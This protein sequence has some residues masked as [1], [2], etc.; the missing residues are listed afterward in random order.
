[1]LFALMFLLAQNP[2]TSNI[3][4]TKSDGSVNVLPPLDAS[5]DSKPAIQAAIDWCEGQT[6]RETIRIPPGTWKI[7]NPLELVTDITLDLTMVEI[8]PFDATFDGPLVVAG[9]AG[10]GPWAGTRARAD[11]VYILGGTL[12][13]NVSTSANSHGMFVDQGDHWR[14]TNLTVKNAKH[15]GIV[16][17]GTTR[18]WFWDHVE[19]DDCGAGDAFRTQSGAGLNCNGFSHTLVRCVTHRCGQG[20]ESAGSRNTFI[21]CQAL[22]GNTAAGPCTGFTLGN[23][24]TGLYRA[25]L[26]DCKS[27]GH[28]TAVSIGNVDGRCGGS[29]VKNFDSTDGT[30]TFAGGLTDNS[31]PTPDQGPDLEK[32][33]FDS[34]TVHCASQQ[35]LTG[36]KY[37]MMDGPLL[38]RASVDFIDCVVDLPN[39]EP[40]W[41]PC[42]F[43]VFGPVTGNVTFLRPVV[44]GPRGASKNGGDFWLTGTLPE[45]MPNIKVVDAKAFK[46]DG[47]GGLRAR[48]FLQA[49]DAAE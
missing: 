24:V 29:L 22:E 30:I 37:N 47:A 41:S 18:E 48:W 20:Y 12:N 49:R 38:G 2:N 11:N 7:K 45:H 44:T 46:P 34:C 19:A 25:R 35:G 14:L 13:Q 5:L 15:E 16:S 17:G 8:Q 36:F 31:V 42:A 21:E 32:T 28:P 6:G 4:I 10:R 33:V 40:D 9:S 1:M 26:L 39:A 27:T 3:V 23:S 43:Q